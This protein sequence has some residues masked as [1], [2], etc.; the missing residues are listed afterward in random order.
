MALLNPREEPFLAATPPLGWNSWNQFGVK[1]DESA[2]LGAAESLVKLGLKDLGYQYVVIDDGWSVSERDGNGHLVA[3]PLRFPGGIKALAAQ[4]HALGL[5]L[6]IYSDAAE[7]T[8]GGFLGSLGFE[9]QDAVQWAQ[10]DIDFLKYDYC[11]APTDQST[12]IERYTRMGDALRKTGRPF[13]YSL[14]E[15]GGRAP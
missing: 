3:D 4:V 1:V 5:K 12:A 8:C 10:W 13:L 9:E 6:G 15:W 7:K 11:N 14:C 2:V